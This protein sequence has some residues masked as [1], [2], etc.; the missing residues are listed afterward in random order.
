MMTALHRGLAVVGFVLAAGAVAFDDR[1][2]GWGAIGL[3]AVALLLRLASRFRRGVHTS[4][5]DL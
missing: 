1:R 4:H 5:P 2:A 3:L